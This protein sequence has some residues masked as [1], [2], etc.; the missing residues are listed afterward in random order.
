MSKGDLETYC[1]LVCVCVCVWESGKTNLNSSPSGGDGIDH[2]CRQRSPTG[3][4][5]HVTILN[6]HGISARMA[7]VYL[8]VLLGAL[9]CAVTLWLVCCPVGD[10]AVLDQIPF[11]VMKS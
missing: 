11:V 3:L 7:L 1:V 2:R 4:G 10:I 6:L 8:L 5:D 9:C